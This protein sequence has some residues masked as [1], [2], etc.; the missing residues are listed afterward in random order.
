M[1]YSFVTPS[2]NYPSPGPEGQGDCTK[3]DT[4]ADRHIL[5]GAIC[6]I[7]QMGAPHQG[8]GCVVL[9]CVNKVKAEA[10]SVG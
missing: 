4:C 6:A 2:C 8:G 10:E 3:K 7:H 5:N 9:N 1:S